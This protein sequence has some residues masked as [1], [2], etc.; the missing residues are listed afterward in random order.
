MRFVTSRPT[1]FSTIQSDEYSRAG[2]VARDSSSVRKRSRSVWGLKIARCARRIR[3]VTWLFSTMEGPKATSRT[4]G[5]PSRS[6]ENRMETW[7]CHDSSAVQRLT[8]VGHL[9]G[10]KIFKLYFELCKAAYR[11]QV[12]LARGRLIPDIASIREDFPALCRPTAAMIGMS[13][14]V[15]TLRSL[16]QLLEWQPGI[17]HSPSVAQT[18]NEIKHAPSLVGKTSVGQSEPVRP[19]VVKA[20]L[21]CRRAKIF[22]VHA[23]GGEYALVPQ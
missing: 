2:F 23:G 20:E 17:Q 1:I 12:L 15:S 4:D 14:C 18:T 9:V 5:S 11:V 3:S 8:S 7:Q 21:A 16:C 6:D 19:S 10:S 13:M 22:D